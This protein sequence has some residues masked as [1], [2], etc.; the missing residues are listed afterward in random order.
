MPNLIAKTFTKE[1][2]FS[3]V[4]QMLMFREVTIFLTYFSSKQKNG[5]SYKIETH[6]VFFITKLDNI[7]S[8]KL[9]QNTP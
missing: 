6:P 8:S 1:G 2:H 3:N 5:C 4:F 7:Q 9:Y